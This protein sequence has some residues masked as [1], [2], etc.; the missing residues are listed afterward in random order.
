MGLT[1]NP[2]VEA[3]GVCVTSQSTRTFRHPERSEGSP[4]A[5]TLPIS[6]DLS[7]RLR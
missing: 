4:K 3:K 1:N 6:G 7:L 5:G 2:K